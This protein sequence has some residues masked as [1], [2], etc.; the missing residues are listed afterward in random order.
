M[1]RIVLNGVGRLGGAIISAAQSESADGSVEVVAGVDKHLVEKVLAESA[2][3]Q[4]NGAG[5][6]EGEGALS[7][8]VQGVPV[9]ANLEQV[10]EDFDVLIDASQAGGLDAALAYALSYDKPL[11][12][13]ATGH[14]DEQLERLEAGARQIPILRSTNLSLGVNVA[15]RL[16]EEAS[17]MLGDVDVE[18]V[19]AHHRMK[20]DA[21]SGT[22]LT[23]AE[24]AR[25]ATG[26]NRPFVY[27]RSPDTP[28]KR[29]NEIAIHAVRGGTVIGE[30]TVSFLLE[31]EV[32]EIR[33]VALSRQVFGYGG[34]AAAVFIEQMP[35]GL[36][37]MGDLLD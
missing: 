33:H 36:Y 25:D 12:V 11:V 16:V 20:I 1:T 30:H 13:A 6:D 14:T 34:L 26:T 19:E 29:G 21:P 3:D 28:G 9:F 15:R 37:G 32:V 4:G 17:K 8:D 27:G 5:K 22:A 24:A 7:V 10:G 31:D 2:A 35:P 18:V 23:L